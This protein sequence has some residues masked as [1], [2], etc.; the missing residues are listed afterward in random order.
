MV[1]E[2]SIK[3][4]IVIVTGPT[5]IGKSDVAIKIA[6]KFDGEVIGAD[7]MQIYRGL[8]I[9]TGK[10]TD[11]EKGNILHH[12]IDII[13]P[14]ME[15]SVGDYVEMVRNK[16]LEISSKN[17]LP[18]IVGGTV[19]YI[20][21]LLGGMN[22]ACAPKDEKLRDE[23]KK[24][25][26]HYGAQFVYDKL[27]SIDPISAQAISPNDVKRVIRA[28]EIFYVTG[29]PKSEIAT[30]SQCEYDYKLLNLTEDRATLYSR[31]EARVDKMVEHGLVEEV[32]KYYK[33]KN[34]QSMQAIGYKELI[35]YFDEK[36]DLE[37]AIDNIKINSRHYAKRQMTFIRSLKYDKVNIHCRD[38]DSIYAEISQFLAK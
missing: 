28:L 23:L 2:N 10:V 22:F 34:C 33:I 20:N 35:E 19:F 8:D 16:I 1:Q 24:D 17:K 29:K 15:F 3:P 37:Q 30:S 6:K 5:G 13:S 27:M 14:D 9:G 11:E 18:I 4:K 31:I 7:S 36:V 12:M 38:Y 32:N 26:E 25:A 21:G